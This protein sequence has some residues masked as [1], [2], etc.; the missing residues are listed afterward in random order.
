MKKFQVYNCVKDL[1]VSS[2]TPVLND[3]QLSHRINSSI[4]VSSLVQYSF[5]QYSFRR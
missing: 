2:V 3:E 5:R 4:F 1:D